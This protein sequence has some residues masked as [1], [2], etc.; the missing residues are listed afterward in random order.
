[1]GFPNM[2]QCI[3]K[4]QQTIGQ[5]LRWDTIWLTINII[6]IIVD[7]TIIGAFITF[8]NISHI[9]EVEAKIR[10]EVLVRKFTAKYHFSDILGR[11]PQILESIRMAREIAN[12]DA[13]ALLIGESGTGKEL[14]AQSIHNSGSRKLGPFVAINCAAL[15]PNL[16]ES[17]LFGY[18][19]GAFTG[20][21]K[22]GKAGLFE[23]AHRG[24]IFLDEISEMDQ[25]GQARLLRVIQERQV[26]RLGDDKYIPIDVRIIAATNKNLSTLAKEGHFRQDLFYRLNVLLL[27]VP[28]LR[29]RNGDIEFLSHH[30][31]E[32]YKRQ[33]QKQLELTPEGFHY[34]NQHAW[35]GNVRELAHFMER[36]VLVVGEKRITDE[37]IK[38]YFEN[39]EYDTDIQTESNNSPNSP[40]PEDT[41]IL[42]ALET[43]KSNIK[44]AA[45][46]LGMA[47]STLYQ[48]L[49]IYKIE[50]KKNYR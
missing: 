20:A 28:P 30:F 17:E 25:Y 35:P 29:K 8:Q 21:T 47:R 12:V 3:T 1:M 44:Q 5:V 4:G 36:L 14:F 23:M 24:T 50:V 45:K 18:V 31:L 19:E 15:P 42:L 27:N 43:T 2:D 10:N 38:R 32:Y 39:R 34:F 7:K 46:L 40:V 16:L 26:M 9:Q 13:T 11:S 49:K 33:Y 37:I 41:K 48:K 22:K 6:P